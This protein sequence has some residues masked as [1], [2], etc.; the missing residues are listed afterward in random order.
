MY[1]LTLET[2]EIQKETKERAG[3]WDQNLLP[4]RLH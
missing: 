2:P 4:Y 3:N 1:G